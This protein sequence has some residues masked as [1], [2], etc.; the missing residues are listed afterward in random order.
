[1]HCFQSTAVRIDTSLHFIVSISK[2][3][4]KMIT[5]YLAVLGV[6]KYSSSCVKRT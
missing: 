3:R 1:M 2:Y 5:D 4:I 6:S